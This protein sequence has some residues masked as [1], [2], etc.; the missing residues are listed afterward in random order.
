MPN[1]GEAMPD[2]RT[3]GTLTARASEPVT[4]PYEV[5][6]SSRVKEQL[7]KIG[8]NPEIKKRIADHLEKKGG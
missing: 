8:I 3:D 1:I 2:E 4:R 7:S 5:G 6:L